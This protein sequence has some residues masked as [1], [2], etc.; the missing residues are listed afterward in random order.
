MM[1]VSK[2]NEIISV[3]RFSWILD[4]QGPTIYCWI[5]RKNDMKVTRKPRIAGNVNISL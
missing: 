2:L 5:N 3:S 4:A 1:A